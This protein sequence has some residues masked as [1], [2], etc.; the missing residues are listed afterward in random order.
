MGGSVVGGGVG[1]GLGGQS[2]CERR[3]E[4]FVK[5]QKKNG[6]GRRGGAVVGGG[7]GRGRGQGGCVR[8][9]EVFVKIQKKKLG[10]GPVGGGGSVAEGVRWGVG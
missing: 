10:G 2:G 5:I 3:I 6:G 7:G 4:V 9:I 8:R 1:V